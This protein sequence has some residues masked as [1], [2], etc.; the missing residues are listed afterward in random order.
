MIDKSS[1]PSGP[2]AAQGRKRKRFM[3]GQLIVRVKQDAVRP[4]LRSAEVVMSA[5]SAKMLPEA[6]TAPLDFL[7]KNAGMKEIKPLFST[8]PAAFT[9]MRAPA[10][11][12][13][14]V[15]VLSSVAHST[16]ESLAGYN[17][18]TIDPKKVTESLMK[19]MRASDAIE[20]VEPMPARYV[21]A[22]AVDPQ[23]NLQWGLRA[24]RWFQAA[25]PDAVAVR[26]AMLDTGIDATHPDLKANIEAYVHTG[27]SAIDIIGHGTHVAGTIAAV[28]NNGVGM[29][30]VAAC[31]LL[32]WKIF[33]DKPD[34]DD[35]E[36]YVDGEMYLQAL[37]AVRTSGARVLNLSIGGPA[38]SQTEQI[39]FRRLEQS[40][41]CVVAAMGNEFNEGNPTS[42]PAAYETVFAVGAVGS[43]LRRASFSN[44]GK[45]IAVASPGVDILSTLPMK[46]SPPHR[47]ESKYASWS[48]TSMATPHVA[49]TAALYCAKVP[50]ALPADVKKAVIKS[51]KRVPD[52]GSKKFTPEHGAGIINLEKLLA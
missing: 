45:H 19:R 9:R 51:C 47:D 22:A 24:I 4:G 31:R 16:D 38:S 10:A 48:G 52:M 36:F 40:G 18:V 2:L 5:R 41:V 26:A 29:A 46:K 42:F 35:G 12:R 11:A 33:G 43:D 25:R 8:Q 21:A 37:N 39:L 14:S 49:G 27:S 34:P 1:I 7:R 6:V 3:P 44:T 50:A 20:I 17:L 28:I 30:G 15:A 13:E 32:I 23:L